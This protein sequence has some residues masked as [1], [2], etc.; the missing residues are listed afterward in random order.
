MIRAHAFHHSVAQLLFTST[1]CRKDIQTAVSFLITQ[2]KSPDEDDWKKM[3][4]LLQYVKCTIQM[5]LILSEDNLNV[6]KW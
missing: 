6:I 3:W 1:R 4:Q 2:V 5:P